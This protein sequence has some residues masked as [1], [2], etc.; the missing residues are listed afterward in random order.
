MTAITGT[1]FNEYVTAGDP[2]AQ[3]GS[4]IE[5]YIPSVAGIQ[6]NAD[7]SLTAYLPAVD[8]NTTGNADIDKQ[9]KNAANVQLTKEQQ[10]ILYEVAGQD[11]EKRKML[12]TILRVENR[13]FGKVNNDA[14]S[15]V[16]AIGAFQFMPKTAEN[17]GV[18]NRRDFRQ[19]AQGASKYIDE[20]RARH[21]SKFTPEV[22]YADYNA[23]PRASGPLARG[24]NVN[25]PEE[26]KNYLAIANALNGG[27]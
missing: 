24:E 23:G 26:T 11:E 4:G 17:L 9:A 3:D 25:L 21:G 8:Y 15:P 13:G 19:S 16:G 5:G 10:Q 1:V 20:V 6:L 18:A 7:G 2:A 14:V 27:G 22:M 12:E